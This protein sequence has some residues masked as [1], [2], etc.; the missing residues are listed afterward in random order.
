MSHRNRWMIALLIIVTAL[1]LAACASQTRQ[2]SEGSTSSPPAKV[3]HIGE[4]DFSRVI[5]TAQAA[6][7][8]GIETAP[9]RDTQVQGV[10][11]RKVSPA[12]R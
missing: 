3:E 10:E 2:T 1:T 9:V 11:L 12:A 7:R 6:K 4:T 5:L 8:L